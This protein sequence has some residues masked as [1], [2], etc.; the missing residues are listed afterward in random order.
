MF[1]ILE[2]LLSLSRKKNYNMKLIDPRFEIVLLQEA[3]DFLGT[4][5]SKVRN[6]IIYNAKKAA[7]VL[8][9][10]LFKKL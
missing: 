6:K 10:E 3:D 8:D 4:L 2:T 1:L 9:P 7:Y 5:D